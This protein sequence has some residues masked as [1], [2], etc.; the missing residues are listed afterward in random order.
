MNRF[1]IQIF[2]NMALI[3]QQLIINWKKKLVVEVHP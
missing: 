2:V 1:I 3:L